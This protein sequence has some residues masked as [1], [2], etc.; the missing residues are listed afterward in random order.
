MERGVSV[1]PTKEW[2]TIYSS[3]LDSVM[4]VK[5]SENVNLVTQGFTCDEPTKESVKSVG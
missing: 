3:D 5:P 4:I 2:V 1:L